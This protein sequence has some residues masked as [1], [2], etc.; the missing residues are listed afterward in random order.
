MIQTGEQSLFTSMM[1]KYAVVATS[2]SRAFVAS[3]TK[4]Q[5]FELGQRAFACAGLSIM[6]RPPIIRRR[7]FRPCGEFWEPWHP[8]R[9]T[10]VS[11]HR[12]STVGSETARCLPADPAR[13][14]P[15][16]DHSL[17]S[18]TVRQEVRVLEPSSPMLHPLSS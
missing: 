8:A 12:C 11:Y 14:C 1:T 7:A 15:F 2:L 13:S 3:M 17:P 18:P 4:S 9:K 6:R 5:A 10:A 16:L